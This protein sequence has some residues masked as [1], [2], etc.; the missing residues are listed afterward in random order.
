MPTSRR[1]A[2]ARSQGR[3]PSRCALSCRVRPTPGSELA[4][5]TTWDYHAFSE[6]DLTGVVVDE[7]GYTDVPL[8]DNPFETRPDMA[9]QPGTVQALSPAPTAS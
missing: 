5:F 2:T 4:L 6:S 9:D 1:P 8:T 7:Y 3:T